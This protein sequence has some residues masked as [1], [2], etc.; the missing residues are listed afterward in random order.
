[1]SSRYYSCRTPVSH[2]A[3]R[4]RTCTEAVLE[5]AAS[6]V[7]PLRPSSRCSEQDSNLH[8][9]DSRSR[10]SAD[11][12]TRASARANS[13]VLEWRRR[14]L[15]PRFLGAGQASYRVGRHPQCKFPK[16]CEKDLNLHL[17]LRRAVLVRSSC[18]NGFPS[19]P[20]RIRTCNTPLL[21]RRPLPGWATEPIWSVLSSLTT[22]H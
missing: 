1:M 21:R 7:G 2:A 13:H 22:D 17:S 5:T 8:Q 10:A 11:W 20:G 3:G 9:R 18:R 4:I 14:D 12:A 16:C 6:A 15:N 19:G